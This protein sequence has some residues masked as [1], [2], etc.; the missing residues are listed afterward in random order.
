MNKLTQYAN[1]IRCP[2]FAGRDNVNKGLIYAY[3][4]IN[5]IEGSGKVAAVTA[6]QV[7]LNS[8]ANDLERITN[9]EHQDKQQG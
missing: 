8:V 6:L 9:E 5:S 2:M 7:V 4:L 3:E 1:S